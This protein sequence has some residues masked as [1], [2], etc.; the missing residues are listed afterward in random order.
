MRRRFAIRY[1]AEDP[2]NAKDTTGNSRRVLINNRFLRSSQESLV[3]DPSIVL[4]F[5]ETGVPPA[6]HRERWVDVSISTLC[7]YCRKNGGLASV[8]A[9]QTPVPESRLC[10]QCMVRTCPFGLQAGTEPLTNSGSPNCET[11]KMTA[12][13]PV[14]DHS[15]FSAMSDTRTF[16]RTYR[17]CLRPGKVI[18]ALRHMSRLNLSSGQR[19]ESLT[20]G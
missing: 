14:V 19:A 2:R 6:G 10:K 13:G 18:A 5:S 20:S 3:S 12:S 1:S 9:W 11:E 4:C 7:R 16:E 8:S 17:Y 15:G